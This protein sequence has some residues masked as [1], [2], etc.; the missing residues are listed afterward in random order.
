MAWALWGYHP[1]GITELLGRP[2]A[3][4]PAALAA[5][6]RPGRLARR[7]S[8]LAAAAFVPIVLLFFVALF[9]RELFEVRYFLVAVPLLFLLV[10]RLVTG[11]IRS[12][13]GAPSPC[14]GHGRHSC[15]A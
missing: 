15:S 2:V 8:I 6:P 1:D 4:V 11:W 9:D 10:A 13:G 14:G 5:A 12:P 3:A 7:R